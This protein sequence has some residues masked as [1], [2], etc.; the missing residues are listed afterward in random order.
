MNRAGLKRGVRAW[1][2]NGM[3]HHLMVVVVV[4]M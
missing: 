4:S 3:T 2:G 1:S